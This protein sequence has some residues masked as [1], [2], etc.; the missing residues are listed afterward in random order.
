VTNS[1]RDY[2]YLDIARLRSIYAQLSG[3]V[4]E[5]IVH[6]QQTSRT[7]ERSDKI[8]EAELQVD[9][10][11]GKEKTEMLVLHDY[12]FTEVEDLLGNNIINVT[13]Y[14]Q[15]DLQLGNIVRITGVAEIDD[16]VR[17]L[18]FAGRFNSFQAGVI[19]A[20][21]GNAIERRRR[22]LNKALL[23]AKHKNERDR[24]EQQLLALS[25]EMI[26]LLIGRNVSDTSID[27]LRNFVEL[28]YPDMFEIKL[29][30]DP[31]T[32]NVFRGVIDTQFL[33]EDVRLIQAKYGTRTQAEL[34]MVGMITSI[35]PAQYI[36]EES[37][38]SP[39]LMDYLKEQQ[40]SVE[41]P[42]SEAEE[43]LE[44]DQ[45]D[46]AIPTKIPENIRDTIESL[47]GNIHNID[48]F[49]TVSALRDSVVLTPLA[50]YQ[51]TA[52]QFAK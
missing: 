49:M 43:N 39:D 31:E 30:P 6:S 7:S 42:V 51:E 45:A 23:Q 17:L 11:L 2:I 32:A 21:M 27:S 44:S 5:A 34:T 19:I 48:R 46:D 15:S 20:G 29:I 18:K 8:S 28:L 9:M 33:R 14:V 4:I 47:Y 16:Y 22:E 1:I 40:V 13:D 26:Q 3:G 37:E 12:L 24:I 36:G 52:L 25:P 38:A 41:E 35:L 10:L 50:V